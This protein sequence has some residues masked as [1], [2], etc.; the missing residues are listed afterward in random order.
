ME[1]LRAHGMRLEAEGPRS[2]GVDVGFL[3]PPS[4]RALPAALGGQACCQRSK[5]VCSSK[6]DYCTFERKDSPG[7]AAFQA[8]FQELSPPAGLGFKC[9]LFLTVG[10]CFILGV[11]AKSG[12]QAL[13]INYGLLEKRGCPL[14]LKLLL[15]AL[16]AGCA[17]EVFRVPT[18]PACYYVQA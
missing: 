15:L 12:I 7:S 17:F 2:T 5:Q 4:S 8:F 18:Q 1:H 14:G 16:L 11:G 10:C 9:S 3:C 6:R 13:P